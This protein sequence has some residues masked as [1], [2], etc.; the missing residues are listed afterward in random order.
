[1]GRL[2]KDTYINP[3]TDFGFKKLF[4]TEF[5]KPLLINFLNQLIGEEAG[6]IK[7]IT[8]LKN[9]RNAIFDLY[10]ENQD[11]E[12]FLVEVQKAKQTYFKDRSVFYSTFPI[13]EQAEKGDWDFKL[14]SVYTIGILDF[15]FPED[16]DNPEIFHHEVKLVDRS[17]N[18]IF[19]DKLTYIYLEMPKFNKTEDELETL[20]DKWLYVFKNLNK[21][22]DKPKKLQEKV[23]SKL[24]EEAR[25]AALDEEEYA[26]YEESLKVY[27][28]LKNVL[29]TS[30]EEGALSKAINMAITMKKDEIPTET[31]MKYTELSREEI[32]RL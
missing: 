26:D 1:M 23:F 7:E 3:F 11:G 22:T 10:C 28:D 4:G 9:N 6:I 25:V 18:K 13:Q 16:K 8:F 27:R 30:F 24:F 5:N 21:L 32:E 2:I 31:I 20:Y 15:V 14:K 29:D 17:T 19:Y 12:K